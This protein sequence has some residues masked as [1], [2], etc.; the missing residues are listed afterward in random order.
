MHA[1]PAGLQ[2]RQRGVEVLTLEVAVEGV[3]E[4]HDFAGRLLR[5]ENPSN[6]SDRQFGN[7][8]RALNPATA[9]DSFAAPGSTSR[10]FNSHDSFAA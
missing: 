4:Q 2:D 9:S 1:I 8:R 10:R 5:R 3:G 6:T 7:E